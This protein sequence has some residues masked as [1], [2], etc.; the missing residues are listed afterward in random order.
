MK[1]G[2]ERSGGSETGGGMKN[3][4]RRL[5]RELETPGYVTR[6]TRAL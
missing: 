3:L 6:P 4:N 1:Q 2:R 5:N